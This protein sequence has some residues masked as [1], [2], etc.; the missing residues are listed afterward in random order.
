MKK[1][2]V[3]GLMIALAF[4]SQARTWTNAEGKTIEAK[5]VRLKD[6][7]V[8]LQLKRR[9]IH[10]FEISKLSEADRDY[11]EQYR[12]AQADQL[13]AQALK[14]RKAKW[15]EDFADAKTDAEE[16][17]LPILLLFTAP[18]WCGYCVQLEKGLLTTSEFRK[19]AN[20]NLV[21]LVAD[22]SKRTDQPRWEKRN[23]EVSGKFKAGGY[24]SMFF[25]TKETEKL[26]RLG[27]YN[28]KWSTSAYIEK[29]SGII[30][31]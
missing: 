21:L 14:E 23:S 3:M 31:K 25:I 26:G 19:F 15:H 18:E 27:G 29:I 20:Q 24:P 6:D 13:K 9:Q 17:D 8:F 16:Y 10:P 28:S 12:Q 30:N 1:T 11:I 4:G 5:L 7:K 22:Y 2:V